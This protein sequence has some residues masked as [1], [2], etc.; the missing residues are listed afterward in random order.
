M[1]ADR[2]ASVTAGPSPRSPKPR[3]RA[4]VTGVLGEILITLGVVVLLYVV[5]QLWIGDKI[6][7]AESNREGNQTLQ[8]WHAEPPTSDEVS[9]PASQFNTVTAAPPALP[10]PGSG[11]DFAVLQIPRFGSDFAFKVAGGTYT[12][13]SLDLGKVGYY[14]D[15]GMPGQDGNFALAGHRGSHGAPFE[16]LPALQAGDA[17]VVTTKQGW[18]TYRFRNMEYVTPTTVDVLRPT[19]QDASGAVTGKYITLTTCSPRYGSTERL[20]AY[21]VF[22]SFTPTTKDGKK[23]ESLVTPKG[24]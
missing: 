18:Y 1:A 4:T 11:E 21:G 9:D 19:P 16:H 14:F 8:T 20:I 2:A 5:W 15:T 23:P 10:V 6:I 22:E 12:W 17:I 13:E 3:R 7:A 24:A